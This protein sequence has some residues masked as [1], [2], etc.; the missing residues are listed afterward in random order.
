[1]NKVINLGSF[2]AIVTLGVAT[3]IAFTHALEWTNKVG[4]NAEQ[5]LF[6]QQTLYQGFGDRA[7]WIE[8]LGIMALL[9]VS[10]LLYRIRPSL[11]LLSGVA[12]VFALAGLMFYFFGNAP[13]NEAVRS[14]TV[15]TMPSDWQSYRDAWE[16]S[17]AARAIL[18]G[19][20]VCCISIATLVRTDK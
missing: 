14:W 5:Y 15:E 12:F 6:V 9:F 16:Q 4:L 1:M 3:G 13:V 10:P 11:G 8:T 19:V 18:F 2:L 17:H 7:G 20:S